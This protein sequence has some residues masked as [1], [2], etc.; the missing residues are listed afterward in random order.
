MIE[1]KK[2]LV[3]AFETVCR[4]FDEEH[5]RYFR[6]EKQLFTSFVCNYQGHLSEGRAWIDPIAGLLRMR[7]SVFLHYPPNREAELM[8]IV[9]KA[10]A[11]MDEG[12]LLLNTKLHRIDFFDECLIRGEIQ[13]ETVKGMLRHVITSSP[14]YFFLMNAHTSRRLEDG[15][16]DDDDDFDYDDY[17]NEDEED[18]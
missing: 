12:R 18:D 8:G 11:R 15:S 4:A 3:R 1:R 17:Y 2:E 6:Q 5:F 7:I 14:A 13:T 16:F 9:S 10:N